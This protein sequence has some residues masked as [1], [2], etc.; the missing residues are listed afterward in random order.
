MEYRWNIFFPLIRLPHLIFFYPS[1]ISL[2]Q[3]STW[4]RGSLIGE[5]EKDPC[6]P[7][8]R[9]KETEQPEGEREKFLVVEGWVVL[10]A[11]NDQTFFFALPTS[12]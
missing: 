4:V 3:R 6:M 8:G 1:V 11:M 7:E 2:L 9:R 10:T 12:L 5:G